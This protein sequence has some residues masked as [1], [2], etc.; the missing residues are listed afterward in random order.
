MPELP[1]PMRE[2]QSM[3]KNNCINPLINLCHDL[4]V[5]DKDQILEATDWFNLLMDP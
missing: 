1:D 2:P 4:A 5:L 3:E